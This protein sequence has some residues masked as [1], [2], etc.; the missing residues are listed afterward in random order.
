VQLNYFRLKQL[1]TR[2][3]LG[4]VDNEAGEVGNSR[5]QGTLNLSYRLGGFSMLLQGEYF[6]SGR[7]DVDETPGSR[8]IEGVGD[9]WL[10]N[11]SI[12]YDVSSHFG[13][14]LAV[15]NLFDKS[16]LFPVPVESDKTVPTYFS[17]IFG[18][19][20]QLSVSYRF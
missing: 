7:W 13:L 11:S 5:N 1:V 14:R 9:W 17:G 8:D 20:Y 6:G 19:N 4:D 18:R 2:V 16:A 10:F 15:D 12:G 3:G